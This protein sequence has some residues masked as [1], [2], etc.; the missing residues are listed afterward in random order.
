MSPWPGAKRTGSTNKYSSIL[1]DHEV[2]YMAASIIQ[3]YKVIMLYDHRQ[4]SLLC[5]QCA[6]GTLP[7]SAHEEHLQESVGKTLDISL[8]WPADSS[9][10]LKWSSITGYRNGVQEL[11]RWQGPSYQPDELPAEIVCFRS[12][13]RWMISSTTKQQCSAPTSDGNVHLVRSC[14]PITAS[15]G[16]GILLSARSKTQYAANSVQYCRGSNRCH[17]MAYRL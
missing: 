1:N 15:L 16:T 12:T 10:Q 4:I 14:M 5:S 2:M 9:T 8:G 6:L 11:T 17:P 7:A 3:V 13:Y